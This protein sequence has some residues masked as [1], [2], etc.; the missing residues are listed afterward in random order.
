MKR[1]V[2]I[3]LLLSSIVLNAQRTDARLDS[4]ISETIAV[5]EIPSMVVGYITNDSCYFGVGGKT[6][7]NGGRDAQLTDMYHLG[8]NTRPSPHSSPCAW[9][10]KD[11][12]V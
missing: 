12:S 4:L 9:S 1:I 7:I 3:L 8:S 11:R 6:Q 10:R 5:H 2:T